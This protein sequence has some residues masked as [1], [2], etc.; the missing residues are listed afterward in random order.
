MRAAGRELIDDPVESLRDL[1]KNLLDIELAN[2][3]LG[4]TEPVRRAV[5]HFMPRTLLDVG[6]GSADIPRA[7]LAD[8][9]KRNADLTITCV[10]LSDQ[11][12]K[13]AR[14][15]SAGVAD[16]RFER[17]D[18]TALPYENGA[19]DMVTCN[20]ALHHFD[21]A[22]AISLMR[23][24]RRVA[25]ATPW[26]CD[27]RRTVHGFLGAWLWTHLTGRHWLTRHDAP[28]SVRRAY[29]PRE[30]CELAR[31]AGWRNPRVQ[32]LPFSRMALYDA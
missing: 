14:D 25:R 26:I 28:L 13:I 15:R 9:R 4:G 1:E 32:R 3:W 11:M 12:L 5:L 17:A 22:P 20:L 10:D 30:A 2:R 16:L 6:S 24:M 7:L 18:G 23:E 21:P 31:H 29:T 27:L 19:F 8:A